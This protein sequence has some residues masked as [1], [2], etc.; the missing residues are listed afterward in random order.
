MKLCH[1]AIM[2]GLDRHFN[3]ILKYFLA[4][5]SSFTFLSFP[6]Y[7]HVRLGHWSESYISLTQSSIAY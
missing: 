5:L 7:L 2:N 3:L 6:S 4:L 1:Y